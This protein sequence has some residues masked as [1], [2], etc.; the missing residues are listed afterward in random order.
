MEIPDLITTLAERLQRVLSMETSPDPFDHDGASDLEMTSHE[1]MSSNEGQEHED[2]ADSDH[3]EDDEDDADD[4]YDEDVFLSDDE[5]F[6]SFDSRVLE[7]STRNISPES[8]AKLNKRIRSDLRS[9]KFAG[10]KLGIL[11]GMKAES[12]VSILSISIQV[13]KLGLSN[14]V[15]QAWDLNLRQH[16]VLLIRYAFGYKPLEAILSEP[17]KSLD[18]SFR[19][20][21][22]VKYKPSLAEAIAAFGEVGTNAENPQ[23]AKVDQAL[24]F[25]SLFISSSLNGFLNDALIILVKIR[26]NAGIG[27]DGAKLYYNDHQGRPY[28]ADFAFTAEYFKEKPPAQ[29]SLP[30][31]MK[32]DHLSDSV[33]TD[34]SFPLVAAQFVMRYL[35]RCTEFCLVCH[36]SLPGAFEALKPYVC[37]NRLCLYQY[38]SLGFGPSMEHEIMTQPYVVDLLVSLCYVAAH[39]SM[40][41]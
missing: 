10:F 19:V 27:W 15:L 1:A 6:K 20:G 41:I 24:R 3:D 30:D 17:A 14:E 23:E 38:M 36:D 40:D 33:G 35:L 12:Q 25:S 31:M 39:V 13:S 37:T 34:I 22:C 26:S 21:V 11:N 2:D 4:Q 28:D 29:R 8:A 7:D 9:A 5:G 16:I 18:I 32:A